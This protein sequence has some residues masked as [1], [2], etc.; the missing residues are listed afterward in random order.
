MM[1]KGRQVQSLEQ[2]WEHAAPVMPPLKKHSIIQL[3][4]AIGSDH[5]GV[6]TATA[7][8]LAIG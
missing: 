5:L 2:G 1:A 7:K 4:F 3:L 8:T 6:P